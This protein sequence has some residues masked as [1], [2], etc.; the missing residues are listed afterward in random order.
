MTAI[1]LRR[2]PLRL[3]DE[4]VAQLDATLP[5]VPRQRKLEQAVA[6][7]LAAR[8]EMG[9]RNLSR[10]LAEH[11]LPGDERDTFPSPMPGDPDETY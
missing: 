3:S 7:W 6:M 5:D 10:P 2:V 9:T 11:P 4:T 1:T 8:R